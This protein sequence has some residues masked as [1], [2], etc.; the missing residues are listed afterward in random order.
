MGNVKDFRD[1]ITEIESRNQPRGFSSWELREQEERE[2]DYVRNMDNW[3]CVHATQYLPLK[4][5]DGDMYIPTTAMATGFEKHPRNTVHFTFNH[6]V[7]SHGYGNWDTVPYVILAPYKSVVELNQNPA[8]VSSTDTYWSVD[9]DVGLRLP[10]DTYIVKPDNSVLFSIGEH[11]ATYKTDNFTD[12]EIQQIESMLSPMDKKKYEKYKN[13][14]FADYEIYGFNGILELLP[15]VGKKMY[16]ASKDKKAFLRGM[17]EEAKFEILSKFLRD[18]VV[19]L[20][21][22]KMGYEYVPY[23]DACRRSVEVAKVAYE[24]G[25]SAN[26]SNK[27]HF[28]SIYSAIEGVYKSLYCAFEGG[29]FNEGLYNQQ[30]INDLYNEILSAREE[31]YSDM[32]LDSIINNQPI[33]FYSLYVKRFEHEAS[34]MYSMTKA[35][36]IAEFDVNLDKTVRRNVDKLTARYK[37]WLAQIKKW[38]GYDEFIVKLKK[39][40][41]QNRVV[42]MGRGR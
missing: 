32:Y 40:K 29:L 21:M 12:K 39:L 7:G 23:T 4:S 27:G 36:T 26:A 35:K 38:P 22:N 19:K 16:A 3:L 34:G 1:A 10:R 20:A 37:Q 33:D 18:A 24:S 30:N 2:L 5:G 15:D 17:Y 13:A 31:V 8:E 14:D 41:R 25:L 11:V 6:V 9:P 42:D 28:N